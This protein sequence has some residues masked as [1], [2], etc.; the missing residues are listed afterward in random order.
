MKDLGFDGID[1]DYEYPSSLEEGDNFVRMLKETRAAL[2]N[3][4]ST[5]PGRPH[6]LLTAAVPAGPQNYQNLRISNM[7]LYLD[8]WNLMAYDYAGSFSNVS[9]HQANLY[10]S[11][12]NPASTP[13]DTDT[14]VKYYLAN[15]VSPSKLLLGMP[16][17]GRA[18]EATTGPGE[19]YTGV[20]SG[21]WENGVWDYKVL[22]K[23]GAQEY[24]DASVGASWSYD[25]AT[26]EMI[27]YD[28]PTAAQAK[29]QYIQSLGLGGAMWWEANGDKPVNGLGSLIK[30]VT[31]GLGQLENSTNVLNY[32]YSQYEN[33]KA[34]MPS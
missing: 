8:M 10:K 5:V 1:I 15:S 18:F 25:N 20:G 16:L 33:L 6:F 7:D 28:T 2:T 23:S 3:Y 19:P 30:L 4:S 34:G 26:K 17:Y 12:S 14:A 9:G 32:P 13:F 31:E 11:A 24:F 22:P 29:L 27:S 21:S